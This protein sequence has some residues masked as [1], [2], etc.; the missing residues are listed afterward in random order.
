MPAS[1]QEGVAQAVAHSLHTVFLVAAPIAALAFVA[2][3]LL[4][5]VPLQR[6]RP[7]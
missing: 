1:V 5:E 4:K 7:G 2:V 6:G 3:L